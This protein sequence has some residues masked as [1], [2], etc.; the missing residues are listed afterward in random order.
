[1]DPLGMLL[2]RP[3]S[4]SGCGTDR[5]PKPQSLKPKRMQGAPEASKGRRGGLRICRT[6]QT[7]A[8]GPQRV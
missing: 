5:H 6:P 7:P 8:H 2:K 1:M 4:R 3:D